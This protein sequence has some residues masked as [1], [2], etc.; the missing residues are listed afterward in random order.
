MARAKSGIVSKKRHKK[1][2]S[3]TKGHYNRRNNCYRVAIESFE[4]AGRYMYRDRKARK[5]DFRSLW[6]ARINAGVREHGLIYSQFINGLKLA[7]IDIDRKVLADMAVRQPS[8]FK[9]IVEQ[10]K[11]ALKK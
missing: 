8:V 3:Y 7:N 11:S 9:E 10:V 1:I 2:L 6:I 4:K 5:R